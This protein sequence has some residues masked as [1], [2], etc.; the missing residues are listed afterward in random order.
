MTSAVSLFMLT[1]SIRKVRD[2][3]TLALMRYAVVLGTN[4][5]CQEGVL[6]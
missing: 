1:G 4:R 2:L 3:Q 5:S 6:E